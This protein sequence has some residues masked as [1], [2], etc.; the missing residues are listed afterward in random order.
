MTAPVTGDPSQPAP[1]RR[2]EAIWIDWGRH[3]RTRSLVRELG[4]ELS[5]IVVPGGRFR[6]YLGSI[7]RTAQTIDRTRP[8]VVFAT[9]PSIVL[10]F[11]LLLLRIRFR[12]VLVSDA[13]YAGVQSLTKLPGF[14]AL[15]DFHNR[16]A[17]LVVVTNPGHADRMRSIGARPYICPDPLPELEPAGAPATPLADRSVFLI[18]SFDVDEPYEA[19]FAAFESLRGEGFVLYVSGNYSKAGIDPSRYPDIRFLGYVSESEYNACLHTAALIMDLT[20]LENCLVCGAY[21][22]LVAGRPLVLSDS[23]ALKSYF[24]GACKFTE[25]S[26][27]GIAAAVRE[28]YESR[29]ELSRAALQ[30]SSRNAAYMHDC[31]AGLWTEAQ[32][33]LE[34]A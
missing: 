33:M 2:S 20:V 5:E 3:P 27:E 19:V 9:N 28:A 25:N 11:L 17:D 21:E 8:R 34:P 10:G 16:H 6:R 23:E 30:W 13:H 1:T 22:A 4:I 18:C 15:L 32:Q 29:E 12:F 24:A 26:P 31:V 14:Q 7:R